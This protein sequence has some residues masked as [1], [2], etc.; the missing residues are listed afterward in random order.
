MEDINVLENKSLIIMDSNVWLDLYKLPPMAIV[1]IVD[2]ISRHK[3]KFWLPYQVYIEFNR[4]VNK[5]RDEALERYKKI[6]KVSCDLL[7]Q[8]NGKINQ[9]FENLKRN[10]IFDAVTVQE[11]F[12]TK[13]KKLLAGVKQDLV[14]L[15]AAYQKDISGI[16][17]ENDIILELIESLRED[18]G[19]NGFTVN[20]LI[21]IYEEGEIRYKYKVSPGYTDIKKENFESNDDFLL[22]KYGDLIIWKE[23]LKHIKNT[24]TN[25]LFIQNE[26]KSDWWESSST[27]KIAK[28]LI[29]EYQEATTINSRFQMLNF[30][31]LLSQYGNDLGMPATT[32]KDIVS[33]LK[34]EKLVW[35]YINININNII[36]L[37]IEKAYSEEDERVYNLLQDISL[38]GGTVES[39]EDL[40][41]QNNNIIINYYVYDRNWD[42]N[43]ISANIEVKCTAYISEY[44]NKYVYHSGK[45][46]FKLGFTITLDFSID[47][48]DITIDPKDAYEITDYE[49]SDERILQLEHGEYHID[50]NFNEDMF[51]DR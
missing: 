51:E 6:K 43:H 21:G 15:D 25:L 14:A 33:K 30:E 41:I 22:K 42:I 26:R 46:T 40:E 8:A 12:D 1:S 7:S 38:F 11:N 19:T 47:F 49:I 34:L 23:I 50:V 36:E 13:I 32:V 18:S 31:H 28:V 5:N 35:D 2:A 45:V 9:E 27:N 20:E 16:N 39:V 17:K 24:E 48:S 3:S 37:Y 10:N 29:Q 4:H 44:V